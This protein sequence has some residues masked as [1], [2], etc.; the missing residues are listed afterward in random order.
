M[1]FQMQHPAIVSRRKREHSDPAY[2]MVKVTSSIEVADYAL[3]DVQT[4]VILHHGRGNTTYRRIGAHLYKQMD[5]MPA[6]ALADGTDMSR[7]LLAR[8]NRFD[9]GSFMSIVEYAAHEKAVEQATGYKN[10]AYID[11]ALSRL[12]QKTSATTGQLKAFDKAPVLATQ[13]WI[14]WGSD[15]EVADWARKFQDFMENVA[16]VDG[17]VHIRSFEPCVLM[18]LRPPETRTLSLDKMRV[19]EAVLGGPKRLCLGI[20]Q[21]GTDWENLDHRYFSL[22]ERERAVEVAE[23]FGFT[24]EFASDNYHQG[25]TVVDEAALSSDFV[26]EETLRIAVSALNIADVLANDLAGLSYSDV[27][28][29][30][31][32]RARLAEIA[33]PEKGLRDVIISSSDQEEI[34]LDTATKALASTFLREEEIMN[35]ATRRRIGV[36]NDAIEFLDAR[37]DAMPISV[38]TAQ[39][40]PSPR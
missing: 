24:R 2:A 3:T 14:A 19:M 33:A 29:R 26:K 25:A 20:P 18:S 9:F 16:V 23:Q 38:M 7:T 22:N 40:S 5:Y 34:A 36:L 10:V 37:R 32:L 13:S 4:A 39:K 27:T 31:A 8:D 11:R 35:P 28:G 17:I 30:E 21:L 1:R 12:E 6:A 15:G